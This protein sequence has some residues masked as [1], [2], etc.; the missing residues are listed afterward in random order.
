LAEFLGR[1]GPRGFRRRDETIGALI[2]FHRRRGVLTEAGIRLAQGLADVATIG[3]LQQRAVQRG[4]DLADQ[5]QA[6][7]SSRLVI[8]QAK[9]VLAEREHLEMAAAFELLRRYARANARP[10]SEVAVGVVS[11]R[12]TSA[13]LHAARRSGADRGQHG[14]A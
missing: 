10:M 13:E 2:L 4:A 6:A 1:G 11:R 12:L 14:G 7:L 8:E 5:L 3:I 9:G